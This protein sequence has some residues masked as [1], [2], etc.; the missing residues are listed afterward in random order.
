MPVQAY[1][2]V[3]LVEVRFVA[4]L[5]SGFSSGALF[6]AFPFFSDDFLAGLASAITSAGTFTTQFN[7]PS[8]NT[9]V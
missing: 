5:A 6:S 7:T 8:P 1:F 2:V 9:S 3:F 4:G